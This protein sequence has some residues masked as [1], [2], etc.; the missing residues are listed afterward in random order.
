MSTFGSIL[1]Q[2]KK[3]GLVVD[4]PNIIVLT[5]MFGGIRSVINPDFLLN[6]K[7]SATEAGKICLDIVISGIL[8]EEGRKIFNKTNMEL[9]NENA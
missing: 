3:E 7:F 8:T 4:K 5:V 6:N 1:D 2:G 9:Q